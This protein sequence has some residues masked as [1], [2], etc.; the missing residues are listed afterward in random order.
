MAVNNN[1]A[2]IEKTLPRVVDKVFRLTSRTEALLNGGALKL[3]FLDA[4]TVKVFKLAS[5][6][7]YDYK[8]GGHGNANTRGAVETTTETF[9]LSQERYSEIPVDKL[10]SLDD[11][12][13]VLGNLA[14]EFVETKAVP[15][16]DTYRFSK[17]AGYTS[18]TFGNRVEESI[19]ANEIIAKFNAGFKWM[20]EQKVP[21]ED[22]VI[23][24]NPSVMQL[25]RN[26]TE[27]A[28]RLYQS[29][30]DKNVRFSI[31]KYEGRDIVEVPSDMFY[32]DAQ[33]GDG[34]YP[35]AGS[36][37]IN[38]LIVSKSAPII[39][40]KLDFAKVYDST[41]ENGQYLGYV[42]YL[43][44]NL[45]YHDLF[46]PDNK[47]VGIYASVSSVAAN[48][49]G[50][51]LLLDVKAGTSG[52]SVINRAL[53]QPAGLIYD[54]IEL[55]SNATT[56]KPAIGASVSGTQLY[57]GAEFTPNDDHNIIVA[58]LDGKAVAVSQ[59]FEDDLPVGQ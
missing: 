14:R 33:V 19:S 17:L 18:T 57:V 28:K 8:R 53:T 12:D 45:Y 55:L 6:G 24:V 5:T 34:I 59:D 46:V 20:E 36:K 13:T 25:I 56:V 50:R 26:T 10:D 16:F 22:Q 31:E 3:D 27:L 2:Y 30:M 49:V 41:G 35:A 58:T 9:T 47:V 51:A 40:R 7:L 23:Y 52:K 21:Q 1:I 11:G 15:E 32:T 48:T 42:G 43:F 4:R 37:V 29:D 44:T 38:F 39:V 54:K